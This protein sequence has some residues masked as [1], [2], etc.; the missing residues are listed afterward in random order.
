MTA[1]P[2]ETGT[3]GRGGGRW[4][5]WFGL[6]VLG[7]AALCLTVWFPRDIGSGFT[8]ENI[9]GRIVPGDAFFPVILVGLMIP[10]ACL[11]IFSQLRGGTARGGEPVGRIGLANLGFLAR[12]VLLT[13]L[14]LLVMNQTGPALVWATNA[15]GLT[16]ASGYRALSGTFPYNVAGFFVGATAMTLGYLHITRHALRLRDG[17][18]AAFTAALL[19]LVFAGLLD[20]VQLPPNADL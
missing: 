13:A 18:V 20:N 10:L 6:A 11:L 14:S 19:I 15:L 3:A 4:N 5:L 17:L 1:R 2:A 16:D 9:S 7:F 8:Q 12:S